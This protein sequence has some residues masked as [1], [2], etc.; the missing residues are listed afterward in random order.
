MNISFNVKF[1]SIDLNINMNIIISSTNKLITNRKNSSTP[2][3]YIDVY[4]RYYQTSTSTVIMFFP[5]FTKI[6]YQFEEYYI[7][8][9][10]RNDFFL[11]LL[12]NSTS[13][14][15]PVLCCM[16]IILIRFFLSTKKL[17]INSYR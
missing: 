2:T 3:M 13:K 9:I 1:I 7:N 14:L 8:C 6:L 5:H 17:H 16:C 12:H 11:I 4:C 10:D 15:I